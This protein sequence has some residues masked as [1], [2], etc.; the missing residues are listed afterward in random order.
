MLSTR[1]PVLRNHR[2]PGFQRFSAKKAKLFRGSVKG[3]LSEF[4]TNEF[5]NVS[6]S[7][8]KPATR[9]SLAENAIWLRV[10]ATSRRLFVN[11]LPNTED[12]K[13]NWSVATL[14]VL[15]CWNLL[16]TCSVSLA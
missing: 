6:R 5:L 1:K 13:K 3:S 4:V 15:T 7:Y 2:L 14:T 12:G 16:D 11:E 10:F 9:T 8:S